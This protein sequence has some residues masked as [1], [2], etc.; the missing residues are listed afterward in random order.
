MTVS[1]PNASIAAG[2]TFTLANGAGVR[3]FTSQDPTGKWWYSFVANTSNS[4]AVD[5]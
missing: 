5:I 1:V 2:R 3:L 4:I